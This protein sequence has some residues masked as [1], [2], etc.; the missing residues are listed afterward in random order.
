MAVI[1]LLTLQPISTRMNTT[2]SRFSKTA[3][4]TAS[5]VLLSSTSLFAAEG[6]TSVLQRY[7]LDGGWPMILIGLLILALIALCVFNYM[8]LG[9][10]KFCPDDLKE[11][12]FDHMVNCRVRSAIELGASHPSYLGRMMAYALP[13]VD[14]RRPEDL[15]RDYVEDAIADFTINEN[16]KKMTLI[17]YISLIA[18]A[19]PMI[20]LFGT[21]L[22]MVGAFG[23]LASG[24]GSAN[25][26]DLA[27]DI[28]VALLTTLWGLVVAIP[29]L[30]A[31]FFFK[32]RLNN[33]V[34]ECNQ[35]AEELLNASIQTVNGDAHLTKIPEGVAV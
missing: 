23:T 7:V 1:G 2:S 8:N 5:A 27:G 11:N 16:R 3:T 25:P 4:L 20:G 10:A 30:T 33:L 26:S 24:D 34:A 15:G 12:L 14:A 32:N 18:Q 29:A 17:N 22:G 13:N 9:K 28:S 19:A 21:V 31:Y 6:D 35:T